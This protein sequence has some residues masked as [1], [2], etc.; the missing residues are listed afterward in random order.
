MYLVNTTVWKTI[1]FTLTRCVSIV[2]L[3]FSRDSIN[4]IKYNANLDSGLLEDTDNEVQNFRVPFLKTTPNASI[5]ISKDMHSC[6]E[7]EFCVLMY[8]IYLYKVCR[9]LK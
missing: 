7:V 8:N 5:S 9:Y 3:I 1:H 2:Q 4:Y 6:C